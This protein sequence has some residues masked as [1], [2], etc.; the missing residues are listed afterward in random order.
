MWSKCENEGRRVGH[1]AHGAMRLGKVA[2]GT[3]GG[4]LVFDAAR[5]ASEAPELDGAL[6]LDDVVGLRHG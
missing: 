2:T 3:M 1:H 4:G 5:A 6:S